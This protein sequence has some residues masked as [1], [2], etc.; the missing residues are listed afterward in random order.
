MLAG[1]SCTGL[2]VCPVLSEDNTLFSVLDSFAEDLPQRV[3]STPVRMATFVSK[4]KTIS[5]AAVPGSLRASAVQEVSIIVSS[6]RVVFNSHDVNYNK[7]P[8]SLLHISNHMVNGSPIS[9]SDLIRSLALPIVVT[10]GPRFS[11]LLL[12]LRLEGSHTCIAADTA[13]STSNNADVRPLVCVVVEIQ[14]GRVPSRRSL[15]SCVRSTPRTKT[16]LSCTT[17]W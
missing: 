12:L 3:H 13:T 16:A 5:Q 1:C 11:G 9:R 7:T 15:H 2:P 17:T 14:A 6:C 4:P 10:S 8:V